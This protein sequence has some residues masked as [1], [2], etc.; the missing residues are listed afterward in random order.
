MPVGNQAARE[1]W[2]CVVTRGFVAVWYAAYGLHQPN[3]NPTHPN[4]WHTMVMGSLRAWRYR[5]PADSLFFIDVDQQMST[6]ERCELA[7][8]GIV[9][10]TADGVEM[11]TRTFL[12]KARAIQLAPFDEVC[13]FDLDLLFVGNISNVFDLVHTEV[14]VL[15]YPYYRRNRNRICNGLWVVKDKAVL[16]DFWKAV[17]MVRDTCPNDDEAALSYCMDKRWF[18]VTKLPPS[19]GMDPWCWLLRL[20]MRKRC[21]GWCPVEPLGISRTITT[22]KI[23]PPSVWSMCGDILSAIHMS[24]AKEQILD[25]DL[26][27][28]YQDEIAKWFETV[29]G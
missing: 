12:D 11:W 20:G 25:S 15:G 26:W 7:D 5:H 28:D 6:E 19:F 1:P 24:G 17:R 4:M 8:L 2:G 10:A 27:R 16:I 3:P 14:G 9:W 29:R 23:D 13:L 22:S 21:L 18:G